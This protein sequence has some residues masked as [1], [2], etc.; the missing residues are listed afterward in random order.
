M[1]QKQNVFIEDTFRFEMK[2][3]LLNGHFE[4]QFELKNFQVCEQIRP[5]SQ[6]INTQNRN[7]DSLK[8]L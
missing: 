8:V 4:L 2:T 1:W 7:S 3:K 5:C 6:F